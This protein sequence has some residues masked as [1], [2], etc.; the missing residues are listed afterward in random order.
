MIV[1]KSSR[2]PEIGD[3]VRAEIGARDRVKLICPI[4]GKDKQGSNFFVFLVEGNEEFLNKN[5]ANQVT[6]YDIITYDIDPKYLGKFA[7]RTS[8]YYSLQ[9]LKTKC[10]ICNK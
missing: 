7:W 3:L 9:I 6:N 5:N 8:G 10:D 1:L 2:K 4:I